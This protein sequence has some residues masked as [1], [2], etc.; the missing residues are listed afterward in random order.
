MNLRFQAAAFDLEG[1]L[2]D[3]ESAHHRG[4][5]GGPIFLLQGFL[6]SAYDHSDLHQ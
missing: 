6:Q 3:L 1:A 2:V 4:H 5:L